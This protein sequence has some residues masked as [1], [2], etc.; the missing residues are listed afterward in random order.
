MAGRGHII[1]E[2]SRFRIIRLVGQNPNIST[3]ELAKAVGVSNGTAFYLLTALIDK[4]FVKLES[5]RS[6]TEKKKYA[7]ILTPRGIREKAKLTLKF[8]ERKRQEFYDLR[9]EI[10]EVEIEA[11][12]AEE[13]NEQQS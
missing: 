9:Q 13:I 8:L 10:K 12:L 3:R 5:F 11:G 6:S 1:Q 4:G 7:Y 2:E